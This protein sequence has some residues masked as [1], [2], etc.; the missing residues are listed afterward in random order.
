MVA[1]QRVNSGEFTMII[2]V[3]PAKIGAITENP[4][5]AL[6]RGLMENTPMLDKTPPLES[7][8]PVITAE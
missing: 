6:I 8:A 1:Y 7:I 5:G 4:A 3:L 2:T